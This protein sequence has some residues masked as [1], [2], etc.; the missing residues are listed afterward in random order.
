RSVIFARKESGLAQL[1]DLRG[2]MI[3]FEDPGS[4]S[5]YFLPKVFLLKQGFS[6]QEKGGLN[7]KVSSGE[8]G[9]IF[10]HSA[11]AIAAFVLEGKTAA[12]AFSTDDFARLDETNK[13]LIS[14]VGETESVPRHLV[15]V[16]KDLPDPVVKRLR[17]ILLGMHQDK[18]GQ[19]I[20]RQMDNT[21]KFDL[22]PGG[23][24]LVRR[25]LVELYRPRGRK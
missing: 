25:K 6:V 21:T 4:T 16:R 20:L 24:E 18:E 3:A 15:S 13:K 8:I 22:L 1:K 9:Y 14:T 12:G 17:D 10:A 5:G 2:K 7:S 23:E 19:Q 11:D